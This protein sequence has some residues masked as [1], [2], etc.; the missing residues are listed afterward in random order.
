[1]S[2][3][4]A[5]SA[6]IGQTPHR[7]EVI[8]GEAPRRIH[9]DLL[10]GRLVALTLAPGSCIADIARAHGLHPQLLY[11]WRREAKAGKLVLPASDAP[12]FVPVVVDEAV[13][14]PCPLLLDAS[15]E[16]SEPTAAAEAISTI[17]VVVEFGGVT[18]RLPGDVDVA[19]IAGVATALREAL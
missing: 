15:P 3:L 10:K 14:D 17:M 13:A 18:V 2:G 9:G 5:E 8:T 19:R 16:S 4:E 11:R 12:A 7:F 1:M 6:T